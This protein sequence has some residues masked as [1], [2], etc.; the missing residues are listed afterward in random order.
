MGIKQCAEFPTLLIPGK[1]V[2]TV[3]IGS[4]IMSGNFAAIEAWPQVAVDLS[5]FARTGLDISSKLVLLPS[6]SLELLASGFS[7]LSKHKLM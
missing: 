7:H 3:K 1:Q 6:T 5:L 2:M 4:N